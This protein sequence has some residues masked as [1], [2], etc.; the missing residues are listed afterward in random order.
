MRP[1]TTAP[2]APPHLEGRSPTATGRDHRID[3]VWLLRLRW[4]AM[5]GEVIAFAVAHHLLGKTLPLLPLLGLVA[6]QGLTNL[7]W[8]AGLRRTAQVS[9]WMVG[10]LMLLD[11]LILTGILGL[12]GGPLNPFSTLYLVHIALAAAVLRT[13]W[14]WTLVAASLASFGA[15]FFTEEWLGS[16][17]A[18]GHAHHHHGGHAPTEAAPPHDMRL[19]LQGMWVAFGTA[20]LFIV[21]FVGRVTRALAERDAELARVREL[22]LR[23]EKL[24]SLATLAAGAAHELATP[25][26]TIAVVAKEL[27]RSF[28]TAPAAESDALADVTLIRREVA[29]CRTILTHM[30]AE[31]GEASGEGPTRLTVAALLDAARDGLAASPA[32]ELVLPADTGTRVLELPVRATAQALRVLLQNAQDASPE[33]EAVE[34]RAE[35]SADRVRLVVRDRGPGMDPETLSRAGEPFYTTKEPGRGMGLGLFLARSVVERLGGHLELA[36]SAT[37]GTTATVT[38]PALPAT[39]GHMAKADAP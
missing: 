32:V 36:S 37:A 18:A 13:R 5:A 24:A 14:T 3:L 2:A 35:A 8:A 17:A 22:G 28:S 16:G 7:I 11:V 31:A 20:A 38:L 4:G 21:Y 33:G 39:N 25:L 9:E 26:S 23:T 29:R 10:S 34:L 12:T 27:E 6:V 19:H 30:A 15:L 1:E